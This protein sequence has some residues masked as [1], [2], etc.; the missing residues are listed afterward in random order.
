MPD[1]SQYSN[2]HIK[3]TQTTIHNL[4]PL[5]HSPRYIAINL[6]AAKYRYQAYAVI[7]VAHGG[8]AMNLRIICRLKIAQHVLNL[9]Y[10]D[11]SLIYSRVCVINRQWHLLYCIA[12][13]T[14]RIWS[15][16]K[17][18]AACLKT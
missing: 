6:Y 10:K 14:S 3:R 1:N 15:T 18:N 7:E 11:Q 17:R 8:V 16:P 2:I 12:T 4:Y 13:E 5:S 9:C